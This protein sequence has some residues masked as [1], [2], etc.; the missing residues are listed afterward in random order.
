[1]QENEA[2][3][4]EV[5]KLRA[6]SAPQVPGGVPGLDALQAEVSKLQAE[7][8]VQSTVLESAERARA[9]ALAEAERCRK[10]AEDA[11]RVSN[12]P[13]TE[14]APTVV[15]SNSLPPGATALL[16]EV[17]DLCEQA[18]QTLGGTGEVSLQQASTDADVDAKMRCLRDAVAAL[19]VSAEQVAAERKRLV[20]KAEDLERANAG[21]VSKSLGSALELAPSVLSTTSPAGTNGTAGSPHMSDDEALR[22][23]AQAAAE[24]LG[25]HAAQALREV[26]LNAERQLAWISKRINMKVD[27]AAPGAALGGT[28][29][30][31]VSQAD[32]GT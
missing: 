13:A 15:A 20:I 30:G 3:K 1:L 9:E 12:E 26:R 19:Q 29:A 31:L 6:T 23:E 10:E 28:G 25:K 7:A 17:H 32:A 8:Q 11:K 16:R 22:A 2:F 14:K 21:G 24:V 27:L 5:D 4:A 18:R